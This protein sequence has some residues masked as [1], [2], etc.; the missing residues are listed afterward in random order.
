MVFC[1]K[2]RLSEKI[3]TFSGF[4]ALPG[5]GITRLALSE[6]DLAA[7]GEFKKRAAEL[8][9]TLE[10]DDLGNLYATFP[11]T[12]DLPSIAMGSHM[13][14][15]RGGGN[16][17]GIYGVLAS[18][19][20][21]EPIIR[22]GIRLRHPITVMVWTNEEGARFEPAMMSSG[23][24]TGKFDR[25]A[26]LAVKETGGKTTFGD[27]LKS[28]GWMG[29]ASLR[30]DPKKYCSWFEPHIEQGPVLEEANLEIGIVEGVVGM[31]NYDI[32]LTGTACHAG[33]TPQRRRKDAMRAAATVI[34][35]LWEK[36]GA[37]DK[38]LVFTTGEIHTTPNI[39]TVVPG[40]VR[41]SLD[42]RHRDP[43]VLRQVV[44][45]IKGLPKTVCGCS[46]S[47]EEHWSRN[48]ICFDPELLACTEQ[49]T[50][51]LGY[52]CRRMYSG[53]GHDAQYV[54][55]ML[56]S[57]MIFI[58][59]KDGLSHTTVE[60]S[61]PEQTWQGANVLLRAIMAADEKL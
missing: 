3:E 49:A 18:L 5:G 40:E 14:S 16:Y 17:D 39:H 47:W 22:E 43:E 58:P 1:S 29:D 21:A 23:V 2:E 9:M 61:T 38:E 33:T 48:T 27:A 7:R 55:E 56:P 20:V 59:S 26:M 35:D 11:G 10:F 41:F 15:V 4:G 52:S 42:S 51:D 37:L 6:A 19:E 24:V 36:L 28:S 50:V 57:V 53:A 60:Y 12:E 13:D 31:V 30:M 46:L 44:S 32:I 25:D 54:S 45:V 8:G 34:L